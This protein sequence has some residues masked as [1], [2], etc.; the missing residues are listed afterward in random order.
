MK[1]VTVEA[2]RFQG[3]CPYCKRDFIIDA[4]DFDYDSDP[5]RALQKCESC[6]CE[7][8]FYVELPV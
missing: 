4:D 5:P 8:E 1:T 2:V 6:K 3:I 7:Q